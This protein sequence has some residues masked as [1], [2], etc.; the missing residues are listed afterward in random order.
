M[1][2]LDGDGRLPLPF[3]RV[4]VCVRGLSTHLPESSSSLLCLSGHQTG[5]GSCLF[6]CG[7]IV[8]V[9]VFVAEDGAERLCCTLLCVRIG[10]VSLFHAV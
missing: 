6:L 8:V 4:F 9:V 3:Y 7:L 5:G 2:A 10:G 1:E